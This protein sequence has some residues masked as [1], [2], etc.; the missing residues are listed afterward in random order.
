MSQFKLTEHKG[1]IRIVFAAMASPC[2]VLIRNT[3]HEF[4]MKVAQ[5]AIDETYRIEQKFS[6]YISDNLVDRMN[7]SNG[8]TITIDDEVCKLLEYARNMFEASDG[9]FDITSGVLRKIWRFDSSAKPPTTRQIQ[10]HIKKI[11]FDKISYNSNSFTMPKGM[12]IDFGG[13]GKEYA[14]DQVA[15]QIIPL[16]GAAEASFLVNFGGD[17]S[18]YKLSDCAPPWTIGLESPDFNE[19]PESYINM[20][21]GC[22]ATSGNT[23]RYFEYRGKRYGHLLNPKTGYPVEH[24]PMSITTFANN[25]VLAGSLSSLAMLKGKDAETFLIAQ[26]VRHLCTW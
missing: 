18:A 13:L 2:E 3:D 20:T 7:S 25:C 19:S 15:S 23:T 4:C 12:E 24:A 1:F 14:V 8:K 9:L 5:L 17:L 26:S 11:G 16:C 22:V 6:R 10:S 21:H